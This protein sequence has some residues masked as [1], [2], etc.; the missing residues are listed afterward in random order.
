MLDIFI[1]IL[2]FFLL[3]FCFFDVLSD[4]IICCLKQLGSIL[5]DHQ[6]SNEHLPPI[7]TKS[8]R[9]GLIPNVGL[10]SVYVNIPGVL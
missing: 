8:S 3:L 5:I 6:V 10:V 7:L 2:S 1:V 9:N 4:L